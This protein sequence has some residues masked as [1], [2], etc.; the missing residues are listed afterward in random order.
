MYVEEFISFFKEMV[1][2]QVQIEWGA[3]VSFIGTAFS[4]ACGWGGAVEALVCAMAIDYISGVLAAY[5]NPDM[6]LNSQKGF[7]GI[8]KKIMIL[9]LVSLAHFIDQ[10]TGQAVVQIVV[11]WFFLGN[12]GLSIIENAAKAGVPVPAKLKDTLEQLSSE[13]YR[14]DDGNGENR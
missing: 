10:A 6:A 8:C 14:K 3:V 12:E 11:V 2:T 4:Y 7:R 5:I 9:L 13:K 1:P